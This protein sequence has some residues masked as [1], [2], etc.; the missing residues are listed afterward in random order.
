MKIYKYK[1]LRPK[2]NRRHFID[3]VLE[4]SI[5]CADPESLNDRDEE[6]RFNYDYQPTRKT[7]ILLRKVLEKQGIDSSAWKARY[8]IENGRLQ[9]MVEPIMNQLIE[10]ARRELGIASFSKSGNENRLWEDYGGSHCGVCVEFEIPENLIGVAYHYVSYVEEKFFH[11]DTWF[12]SYL[13][14][15]KAFDSYRNMLLTKNKEKWGSQA[16]VRLITSGQKIKQRVHGPVTKILF[17]GNV[18]NSVYEEMM[19]SISSHCQQN[20]IRIVRF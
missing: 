12:E 9:E 18:P 7:E 4:N 5:W 10:K 3:M 16:E 6:F 19:K 17:G 2:E 14:E 1:D 13:D 11:I 8:V 15:S 20:D